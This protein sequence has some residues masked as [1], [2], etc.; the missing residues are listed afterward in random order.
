M[1]KY[2]TQITYNRPKSNKIKTKK[3]RIKLGQGKKPVTKKINIAG[4]QTY[5][6]SS[7][8]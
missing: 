5:R 8:K 1:D 6:F 3:I 4:E 7:D 2:V